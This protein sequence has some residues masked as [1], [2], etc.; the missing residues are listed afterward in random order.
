MKLHFYKLFIVIA[1]ALLLV[2]CNNKV[3]EHKGTI[4]IKDGSGIAD[5]PDVTTHKAF[6]I[7]VYSLPLMGMAAYKIVYYQTEND[8]VKSHAGIYGDTTTVYNKADY[9]W[10]NDTVSVRLYSDT[11]KKEVKLKLYGKGGSN[12]MMQDN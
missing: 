1:V 10:R 8:S 6:D 4:A 2:A 7:D 9:I 5:A 12:A 11:T 3:A